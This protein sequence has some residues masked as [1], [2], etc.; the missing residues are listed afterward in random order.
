MSDFTVSIDAWSNG[1]AIPARFAFGTLDDSG[2]FALSDNRSPAIRWTN[3]PAGTQSF[4]II[5][6][7]PDVPSVAD[8][9]NQ[10]GRVVPADLPRVDFYH[11]L[12]ANIPADQSGLSEGTASQGVTAKGKP[13]GDV[14]YGT[15][16]ANTY[17]HWFAGD[18]DMGGTYGGYDGPC[19]PWNDARMHRYHFTV[20]ALST[21][22]LELAEGFDGPALLAAMKG[23]VLASARHSGTYTLNSALR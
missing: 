21:S 9:V 2:S 19:P 5:T 23:H 11:W 4:A 7:D 14:G 6:H 17:T 22:T 20:Y 16:G 3:A 15:V 12:V 10:E 18:A 1:A 13:V 8:D